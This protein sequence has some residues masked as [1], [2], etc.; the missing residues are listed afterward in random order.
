MDSLINKLIYNMVGTVSVSSSKFRELLE[1]LIQNG[2]YT[3][4]E[5]R[6]IVLDITGKAEDALREVRENIQSRVDQ[7]IQNV[8]GPVQEQVDQW[9]AVM[10]EKMKELPVAEHFIK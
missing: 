1:D 2:Q 3:E 9:L 8:Q 7:A 6:R 4:D 5:G 10:K